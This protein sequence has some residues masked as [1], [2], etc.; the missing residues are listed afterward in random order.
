MGTTDFCAFS[1]VNVSPDMCLVAPN[2]NLL[3]ALCSLPQPVSL[4]NHH[5]S[6]RSLSLPSTWLKHLC[7]DPLPLILCTVWELNQRDATQSRSPLLP[8]FPPGTTR[9]SA[10]FGRQHIQGH[11]PFCSLCVECLRQSRIFQLL[12]SCVG[13]LNASAKA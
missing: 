11:T 5:P 4:L 13:P 6:L 12:H 2:W 9:A 7:P 8:P 3:S 10:F 1:A